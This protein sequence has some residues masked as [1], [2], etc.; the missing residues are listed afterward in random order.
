MPIHWGHLKIT[1]QP[2]RSIS[3]GSSHLFSV[4]LYAYTSLSPLSQVRSICLMARSMPRGCVAV[5]VCV[6]VD[7]SQAVRACVWVDSSSLSS[8]TA[9]LSSGTNCLNT[10]P[11]IIACT[12][13]LLSAQMRNRLRGQG[14]SQGLSPLSI[15]L[16]RWN[17]QITRK[18]SGS[19]GVGVAYG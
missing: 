6:E 5:R 19:D 16:C 1:Y 14:P 12:S 10:L 17:I 8:L 7:S 18:A 9:V 15:L 3:Y 2:L 11:Q 13:S 4:V